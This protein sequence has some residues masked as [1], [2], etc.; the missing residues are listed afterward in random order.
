MNFGGHAVTRPFHGCDYLVARA[1]DHTDRRYEADEPFPH[2][3]L[4]VPESKAHELW[5][6]GYLKVKTASDV[7]VPSPP[8]SS[9]A[10]V[11]TE[12]PATSSSAPESRK[13]RRPRG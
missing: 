7:A 11:V 2:R 10:P 12:E 4:G 6:A 5:S 9:P 13:N 8:V 3:A 1:F